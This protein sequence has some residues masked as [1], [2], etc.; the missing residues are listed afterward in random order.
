MKRTILRL[1]GIILLLSCQA[2]A[3]DDFLSVKSSYSVKVTVEKLSN[4]LSEKGMTIFSIIDHQKGAVGAGLELRPTTVVIFGNPKVG[5]KLME[6]DQKAG[7]D[8]PLKIVIW[9]DTG[10]GTWL[11][12][13]DPLSL[14]RKYDLKSCSEVILKVKNAM[15]SFAK[16][17]TL[18]P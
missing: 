5:T 16:A 10:G 12:Y 11:G 13:T 9:E 7:L 6:C 3:Q 1:I 2:K 15:A 4:V 8:L 14:K 18:Q 17:A